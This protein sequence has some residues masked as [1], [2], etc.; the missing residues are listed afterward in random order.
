MPVEHVLYAQRDISIVWLIDDAAQLVD[1]YAEEYVD[2]E[3]RQNENGHDV[4]EIVDV[5]A[6]AETHAVVIVVAESH[7]EEA[8]EREGESVVELIGENEVG[9]VG[10]DIEEIGS[11]TWREAER[12]EKRSPGEYDE[13]QEVETSYEDHLEHGNIGACAKETIRD[14][15]HAKYPHHVD[16]NNR[17]CK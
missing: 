2:N 17:G 14:A 5:E 9:V 16:T 1:R 15:L 10:V 7:G 12:E 3:E 4:N 11:V 8:D 6:G 13:R